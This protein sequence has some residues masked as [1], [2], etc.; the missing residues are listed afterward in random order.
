MQIYHHHLERAVVVE[1]GGG[2]AARGVALGDGW[3]GLRG[4][5]V[6]L[7]IAAVPVE[8]ALLRKLLLDAGGIH[9]GIDVA[10]DV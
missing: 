6:E 8:R 1:V 3:P 7:A 4:E 10:V 5:I 2:Q 9:L